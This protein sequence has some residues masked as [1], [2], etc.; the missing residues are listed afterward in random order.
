[1]IFYEYEKPLKVKRP[2]I[3]R[4]KAVGR[5]IADGAGLT[6]RVICFGCLDG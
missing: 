5:F 1:M 6:T 4:C 2:R 3:V